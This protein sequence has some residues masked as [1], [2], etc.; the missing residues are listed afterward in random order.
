[1]LVPKMS[2]RIIVYEPKSVRHLFISH[3]TSPH[4]KTYPVGTSRHFKFKCVYVC[5][6]WGKVYKF[7]STKT[8]IKQRRYIHIY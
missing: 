4:L 2:I 8:A 6:V 5:V 7:T 3:P 1:M